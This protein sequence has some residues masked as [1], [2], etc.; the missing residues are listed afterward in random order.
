MAAASDS[1]VGVPEL[2]P[3]PGWFHPITEGS[4]GTTCRLSASE[5]SETERSCQFGG[6]CLSVERGGPFRSPSA[7]PPGCTW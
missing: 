5:R 6:A 2:A 1:G 7:A 4:T 3:K